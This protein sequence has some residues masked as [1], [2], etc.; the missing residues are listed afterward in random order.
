[1]VT[2][3]PLLSNIDAKT[4]INPGKI[5]QHVDL[6]GS[7]PTMHVGVTVSLIVFKMQGLGSSSQIFQ[8]NS[9]GKIM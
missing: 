4:H 1:M 8:V 3:S 6:R 5:I 2:Y 9:G 7:S